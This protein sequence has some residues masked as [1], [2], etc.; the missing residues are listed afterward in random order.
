VTFL[1]LHGLCAWVMVLSNAAAG[2]WAMA[3]HRVEALRMAPLWW[4][5]A[6]A[7]VSVAVQAL[8]GVLVL[9]V[10]G[11]EVEQL[12]V[13]YGFVS[14]ASIGIL[15]SYRQQIEQWRFLLYGFG[16]LFLMGMGIRGMV[17]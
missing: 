10:D 16:G 12:H 1:E 5:T 4:L 17:L 7:Q 9:Q 14:L 2:G 6:A 3:A 11:L 13:I 8:L 15:Y